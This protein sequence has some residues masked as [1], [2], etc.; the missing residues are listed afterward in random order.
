MISKMKRIFAILLLTALT[1]SGSVHAQ[2]WIS[3]GLRCGAGTYL[4]KGE[5]LNTQLA[6][7][8]AIDVNYTYYWPLRPIELGINTGVSVGYTS[9]GYKTSLS[10]SYT[11][12][13][14]A[15]NRIDYNIVSSKVFEQTHGVS[16]EIPA[17]LALRWQGL[18]MNA[19][20]KLQIPVWRL[21]KQ[22]MADISV[23]ATYPAYG[24]TMTNETITGKVNPD[25]LNMIVKNQGMP[26]VSLLLS[27]EIGYEW[28]ISHADKVG[29]V[30]Y[31]DGSPYGYGYRSGISN[32][33]VV[34]VAPISDAATPAPNVK[35]NTII[36]T[37]AQMLNYLAFGAK[38]YYRFDAMQK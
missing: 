19:G 22:Q 26:I 17:M 33:R 10:E 16:L 31:F 30:A 38:V 20:L 36:G 12:Y 25:D 4:A 37:Q 15:G 2:H 34:D 29:L 6:P 32:G 35:V 9:A 24:V 11:N 13:D 18:V 3:T 5:G 23:Q 21:S 1:L 14:Y 27:L 7:N 8:F 28:S